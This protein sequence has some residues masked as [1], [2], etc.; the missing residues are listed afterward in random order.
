MLKS[1][2]RALCSCHAVVIQGTTRLVP[3][4][5]ATFVFLDKFLMVFKLTKSGLSE[6]PELCPLTPVSETCC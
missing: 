1:L 5:L 4:K 6:P 2:T 3:S